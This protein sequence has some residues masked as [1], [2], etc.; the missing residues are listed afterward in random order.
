MYRTGGAGGEGAGA[1]QKLNTPEVANQ[2]VSVSFCLC[3]R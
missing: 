1:R 3:T 2:L